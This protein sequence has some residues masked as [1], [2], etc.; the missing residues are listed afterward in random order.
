MLGGLRYSPLTQIT[1]ENVSDLELAWVHHNG[2]ISDGSDGS[3]RTS[4]NATPIMVGDTLYFCTGFNR[5]FALDAETGEER[6]VF[7]PDQQL[8]R[9]EG[10]YNRACRG[11]A[12]WEDPDPAAAGSG[13]SQ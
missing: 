10:P 3:S 2:D 8:T 7:D 4:F 9:M 12:Y 11:V 5:V 6:W 13:S 1:A